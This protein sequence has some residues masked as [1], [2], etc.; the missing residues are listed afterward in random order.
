[1]STRSH[2]L[3]LPPELHLEI[4]KHLHPVSSTCLGLTCKEFYPIHRQ[5]HG[6]VSLQATIPVSPRNYYFG[7][8]AWLGALLSTWA[9]PKFFFRPWNARFTKRPNIE[10]ESKKESGNGEEE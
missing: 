7:G 10:Q 1:M 2:L 6:A 5:L 8:F 3:A 9:G 4:F